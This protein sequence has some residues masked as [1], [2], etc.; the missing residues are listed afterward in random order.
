V[1]V[2]TSS[3]GALKLFKDNSKEFDLIISD[4]TMPDMNGLE[5]SKEIKN[6]RPEIPIIICTG[7]SSLIDEYNAKEMGIAALVIKPIS[8]TELSKIIR[9]IFN[10]P[11]RK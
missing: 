4:M 2:C 1:E 5:F 6:I 9:D 8:M 11:I 3:K 10:D 7:H